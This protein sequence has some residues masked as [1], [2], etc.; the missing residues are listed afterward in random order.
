MGLV[1][2]YFDGIQNWMLAETLKVRV[3]R[4]PYGYRDL[5]IHTRKSLINVQEVINVQRGEIKQR[6]VNVA[7]GYNKNTGGK[8]KLKLINVQGK[9]GKF[10]QF[11]NIQNLRSCPHW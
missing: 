4:S 9:K 3:R 10:L 8:S 11:V 7:T 5:R 2:I 1:H 6:L